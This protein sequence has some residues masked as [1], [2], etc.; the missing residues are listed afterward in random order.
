MRLLLLL[1]I[2]PVFV[3]SCSK[4]S[5]SYVNNPG[6]PDYLHTRPVGASARELLASDKYLSLK[7]EILYM[8]GYAPDQPAI[9]H[10]Q[11]FLT[12]LINKPGGISIVTKEIPASG[13]LSMTINDI[14]DIEKN[15]RTVFTTG[16]QIGISIVYT[17]GTFSNAPTLGIA[18][19][20]TSAAIFGKTLHENSGG[21]GQ[22]GRTKLEATILEHEMGH[23]LGLVDLGTD[24]QTPHRDNDHGN[25]CN[26]N[27][28]LMY[29]AAETTDI[30]GFL[31]TAN[32]PVLDANC[33]ADLVA[34]GGR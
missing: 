32:I 25:H 4:S 26:N 21:I 23:L 24:M 30:L 17:N 5:T 2:L 7:I 3:V 20:N 28:C 6:S 14:I 10:M 34:N 33:R 27:N 13:K 29:F 22:P 16:T 9:E 11:A 1:L 19:R 18:Y 8:Q 12:G 31:L 15:Q